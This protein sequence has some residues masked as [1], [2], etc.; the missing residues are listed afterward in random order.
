MVAVGNMAA[1]QQGVGG[2]MPNTMSAA[3]SAPTAPNAQESAPNPTVPF[4]RSAKRHVEQG[5]TQSTAT[6]W[7]ANT[8]QQFLVPS[9]GYL[10]AIYLT[11]VATGGTGAV[12]V[13][14]ADAPGGI[15][16]NALANILVADV[17]GTP[18]YNLDGFAGYLARLLGGYRVFRPDMSSF[19]NQAIQT[20]G[21]FKLIHEI[22]FEFSRRGGLGALPNMDASA[23]YKVTL[24]YAT[25]AAGANNVYSTAPTTAPGI[26]TL[27]ELLARGRPAPVDAY[28]NSQETEP[29]VAG[30]IGY[31][32]SQSFPVVVGTNN[33]ILTR[34]GNIIRNHILLFRDATG[35]RSGADTNVTPAVI[36]YDWDAAQRYIM[37]VATARQIAYEELGFDVPAGVVPFLNTADP[38]GIAGFESGEEYIP[39]VG[40]TKLQFR[41]TAA[42]AGTLQVITN[43]IIPG[44]DIFAALDLL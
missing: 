16:V 24:T 1:K 4:G 9:Y 37:N 44:G 5:A 26:T 12:A 22:F 40:A 6:P 18:L 35:S 2:T 30:T 11:L 13:A 31:W 28:G 33:I 34:T 27:I 21:N 10:C 41:F 3:Q 15:A 23:A 42:N 39:T 8:Q 14:G 20:S 29:P 25:P 7:V 43:D 32:S 17:N 36:E 19:A 38:D